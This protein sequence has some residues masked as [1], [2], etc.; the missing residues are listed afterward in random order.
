MASA[1]S[2]DG[3][4]IYMIRN[5]PF[6]SEAITEFLELLLKYLQKV[7][8]I[9]DN[10]SIHNSK[11]T[12]TWLAQASHNE[13]LFLVQQPKYSPELNADEQV[14]SYL[15]TV[16]LKNTCNQNVKELKPKIIQ[17]MEKMK[18]TPKLIQSFFHHPELGFYI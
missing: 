1:I 9:W 16:E 14:W 12:R 17:A 3:D 13:R 7:L 8:I 5:K 10:A 15:K 6:N 11:V 18:S 4:L 2:P